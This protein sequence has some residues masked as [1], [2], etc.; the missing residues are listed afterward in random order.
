MNKILTDI[1][2]EFKSSIREVN[3]N[4]KTVGKINGLPF[5]HSES[6]S[7][8]KSLV[9]VEVLTNIPANYPQMLKEIWGECINNPVE[10]AKSAQDKGA[11]ILAMRFNIAESSDI[12]K[13][14]IRSQEILKQILEVINVPV[15]ILG[16]DKR[17]LDAKL[18]PALAKSANKTCTVGMVIEENYK[19]II[20]ALIEKGHNV[21]ARTPID[22]NLAKQLNILI[23]EM[24]FNLDKII[25]DPN[26]GGLGYGL[27]YAYSIIE[28]IKLAAL[29]GDNM[30]NMPIIAFVG[31]E[32]WKTKEA[33][34]SEASSEWGDH[35]T[36]A[37]AWETLTA[38]SL[39]SAGADIVVMYNPEAVIKIKDFMAKA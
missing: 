29:E 27:D 14:I 7:P 37:V 2:K 25:I 39:I 16:C 10:W 12:E 1:K 5:I 32:A 11:D 9:A 22:I 26:I 38:S 36:R 21:I 18:L 4:G 30:L 17:E 6:S 19:E 8:N 13:E 23:S 28:R 33:K 15:L 34:S 31:E 24:G 3:L 35:N 20:P